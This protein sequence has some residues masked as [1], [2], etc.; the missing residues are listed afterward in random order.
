MD[1]TDRNAHTYSELV[2]VLESARRVIIGLAEGVEQMNL[3]RGSAYREAI[4]NAS[5]FL[6]D[7]GVKH[8][9]H[10]TGSTAEGDSELRA[11]GDGPTQTGPST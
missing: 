3:D 2:R 11:G 1:T 8:P 5:E 4:A 9:G 7:T 10:E 6:R